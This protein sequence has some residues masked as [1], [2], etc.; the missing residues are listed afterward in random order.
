MTGN[1]TA[2]TWTTNQKPSDFFLFKG[3][4]LAILNK[5]G[6]EKIIATPLKTDIFAEGMV[7]EMGN[8]TLV[9]FGTVKKSILKHFDI[10]QEVLFADFNWNAI[11]KQISSNI[12]FTEIPKYPEVRRD[13]ALLIDDSVEFSQLLEIAKKT[14]KLLLKKID[15]FDVY[16]GKNI[17][18]GKKSY[19]ISF[20][21]QDNSKT[22]TDSQIEKVMSKLTQNFQNELGATLR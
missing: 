1:R 22:L 16:E 13:L 14:E 2:E 11:L 5:L 17:P 9:E 4:V 10:K 19:A 3:Y 15:L 12:K 18:A 8:S 21:L 20:T 6:L 7:Y